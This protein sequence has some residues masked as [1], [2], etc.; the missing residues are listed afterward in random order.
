[1]QYSHTGAVVPT[2]PQRHIQ[3]TY[4]ASQ[5]PPPTLLNIFFAII[6]P[7]SSYFSNFA[8]INRYTN[9]MSDKNNTPNVTA[10][11]GTDGGGAVQGATIDYLGYATL[12]VPVENLEFV[13]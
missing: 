5:K 3:A 13:E 7:V 9:V 12:S 11:N 8:V 2:A 1:M 10:V 6:C 4:V